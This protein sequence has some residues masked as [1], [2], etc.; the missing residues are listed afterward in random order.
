MPE[1][2]T[3]EPQTGNHNTMLYVRYF[4]FF[5]HLSLK[6]HIKN[7]IKCWKQNHR[8]HAR[9]SLWFLMMRDTKQLSCT[10]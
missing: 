3:T 10:F 7:D 2:F 1:L 9:M 6:D 4:K 8:E 5:C